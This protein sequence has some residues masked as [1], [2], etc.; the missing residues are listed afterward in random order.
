MGSSPSV[1]ARPSLR[2]SVRVPAPVV[3]L[4]WV[5]AAS[6]IQVA[7]AAGL[8]A[9]RVVWAEDGTIFLQQ[10][11]DQSFPQ[12]LG[13]TYAGYLHVVPRLLAEPAALLPLSAAAAWLAIA[14]AAVASLL[15]AYVWVAS[16]TLF[17]TRRARALLVALF[18]LAPPAVTELEATVANLHWYG[19]IASCFA[20]LHRPA[21]RRET[22]AGAAVVG[23]T[24]LS[25]PLIALL[26]PLVFLRPGGF[27]RDLAIPAA[28]LAGLAIQAVAILGA[29]GPEPQAGFWPPD[30]A[31]ILAQ[32]VAG[33]ALIGQT[34]FDDLWLAVGWPAAWAALAVLAALIVRAAT[35]GAPDRRRHAQ[36]AAGAAFALFAL[37][38]AIRGTS[39]MAPVLGQVFGGGARYLFAPM[40]LAWVPL[41][42]L[43][44]RRSGWAGRIAV[45]AVVIVAVSSTAERSLG[46]DWP[47]SVTAASEQCRSGA[48]I[49]P[50]RIAPSGARWFVSLPCDRL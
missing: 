43:A 40:V 48:A 23:L 18:L 33:P 46:P 5:V 22:A 26:L 9:W 42:L 27:K 30:L 1:A 29:T 32:R 38:L 36:L 17:E 2:A 35:S 8:P 47:D 45:L 14:S 16:A 34:R 20:F 3:L 6:A 50:V 4:V 49:A 28:A 13:T 37:P 44:D 11:L 10:A 15:A 41:L 7:R 21:T 24:A 39:E 31:T 12:A 19:L 25:D